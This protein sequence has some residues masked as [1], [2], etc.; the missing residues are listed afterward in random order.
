MPQKV[1][2]GCVVQLF[3]TFEVLVRTATVLEDLSSYPSFKSFI[4]SSQGVKG[5]GCIV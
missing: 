5:V 4:L 1:T 3:E 2:F